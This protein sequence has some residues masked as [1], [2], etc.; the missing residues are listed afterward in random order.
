MICQCLQLP[1]LYP[2]LLLSCRV[3]KLPGSE[4]IALDLERPKRVGSKGILRG[5][6][7]AAAPLPQR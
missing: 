3:P 6:L 1:L 5:R 4:G 7:G 2:H